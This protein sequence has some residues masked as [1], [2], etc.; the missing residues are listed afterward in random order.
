MTN[1]S[2]KFNAYDIGMETQYI[3]F[4][5]EGGEPVNIPIPD[6]VLPENMQERFWLL[7]GKLKEAGLIVDIPT[8]F[9]A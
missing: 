2:F 7:H 8:T 4:Q 6:V 5:P 3:Q 9:N 1:S